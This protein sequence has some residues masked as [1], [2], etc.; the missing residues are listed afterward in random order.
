MIYGG[1]GGIGEREDVDMA[2]DKEGN[3]KQV[4]DSLGRKE[5][6]ARYIRGKVCTSAK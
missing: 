5:E 6:E 3:M 2:D 1:N 4:E